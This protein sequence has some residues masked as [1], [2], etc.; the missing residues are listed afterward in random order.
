MNN[1]HTIAIRV[2]EFWFDTINKLAFQEDE[3][4]SEICRQLIARGFAEI[5]E[6]N[7]DG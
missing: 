7:N 6:E 1:D 4:A 3:S 2:N 5:L